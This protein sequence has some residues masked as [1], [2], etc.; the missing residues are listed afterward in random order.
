MGARRVDTTGVIDPRLLPTERSRS[1]LDFDWCPGSV[2]QEVSTPRASRRDNYFRNLFSHRG[3][4]SW[5]WTMANGPS[6][7]LST[8][9]LSYGCDVNECICARTHTHKSSCNKS[10]LQRFRLVEHQITHIIE[11]PFQCNQCNKSFSQKSN[12][13]QYHRTHTG[14]K[15]FHCSQCNK[16]FSP[17]SILLG[18]KEHTLVQAVT[19]NRR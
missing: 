6:A 2:L 17:R 16:S 12:L 18:I 3:P 7:G 1:P 9:S 15:P 4:K 5:A 14:E 13:V 11:K 10:F 8:L 19:P